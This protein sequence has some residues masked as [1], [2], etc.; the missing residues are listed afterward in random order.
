MLKEARNLIV[1]GC[2]CIGTNQVDLQYAAEHGI[3]V[4][5]SPFS[6]SRSVAELVIAEIIALA[7]QLGDRSNEMHNG[8]WNKVSNKCWEIRGKTLGRTP[9][10][11]AAITACGLRKFK[12][13]LV[14][15]TSAPSYLCWQRQWA[16]PLSSMML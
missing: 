5:N 12:E 3:A 13:S 9:T 16:C 2:F 1:V 15:V 4:F 8:T 11:L 7:R 10:Y 14:T 6:N